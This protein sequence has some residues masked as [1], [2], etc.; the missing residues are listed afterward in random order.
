MA[1][2]CS[3]LVKATSPGQTDNAGL[4]IP[5]AGPF[6]YLAENPGDRAGW[7]V[8]GVGQLIG[9]TA[10]ILSI[11]YKVPWIVPDEQSTAYISPILIGRKGYGGGLSARF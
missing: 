7:A 8:G 10:F 6:I 1:Y 11:K 5:L 9:A 4:L 3:R 2:F